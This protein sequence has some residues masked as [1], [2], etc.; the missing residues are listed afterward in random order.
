[1]RDEVGK[2]IAMGVAHGVHLHT[3]KAVLAT[4][5]MAD[6]TAAVRARNGTVARAGAGGQVVH[7]HHETNN[8]YEINARTADFSVPQLELVQRRSE[9]RQRVGRPR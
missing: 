6:M 4:Q 8:H 5:R 9:A 1:M 3:P 2:Q 7:H